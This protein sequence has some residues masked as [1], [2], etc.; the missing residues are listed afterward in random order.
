MHNFSSDQKAQRNIENFAISYDLSP[1][2]LID[3]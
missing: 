1:W 3:Y 2:A